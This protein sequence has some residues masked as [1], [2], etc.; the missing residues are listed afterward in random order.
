MVL[1]IIQTY[2]LYSI[3]THQLLSQA[4]QSFYSDNA[5]MVINYFGCRPHSD[6]GWFSWSNGESDIR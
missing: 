4:E 1:S 3:C 6:S 2:F 5:D